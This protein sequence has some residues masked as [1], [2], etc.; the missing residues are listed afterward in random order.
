M[1]K[2]KI[3]RDKGKVHSIFP[4][5]KVQKAGRR[6]QYP[7]CIT[8]LSIYNKGKHCISHTELMFL[9]ENSR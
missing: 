5:K 1:I 7:G 3:R 2:K 8:V 9:Y 4:G 6:C